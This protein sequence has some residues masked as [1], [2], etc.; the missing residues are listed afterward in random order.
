M[1]MTDLRLAQVRLQ[2]TTYDEIIESLSHYSTTDDVQAEGSSIRLRAAAAPA[3]TV[4]DL[5]RPGDF[6]KYVPKIARRGKRRLFQNHCQ[7]KKVRMH[8]K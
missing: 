5:S 4:P 1:L 7:N 2:T 3:T 8:L 6:F